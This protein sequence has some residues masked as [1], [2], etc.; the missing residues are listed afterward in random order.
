MSDHDPTEGQRTVL[1][2]LLNAQAVE[3]TTLEAREGQVWDTQELQRD[4]TV[5]GF[6]APMVSVTRKRDG[7]RGAL[8]FQVEGI[9]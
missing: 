1:R 4:F 7:V 5:H 9:H 2:T 8:L 3:R 6:L